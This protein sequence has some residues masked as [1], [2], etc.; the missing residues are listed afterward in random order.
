MVLHRLI[1]ISHRL[2]G[3]L[4]SLLVPFDQLQTK[5]ARK[6]GPPRL[7]RI[8]PLIENRLKK[9][10]KKLKAWIQRHGIEAYRLYDR[11]IPEYPFQVDRYNDHLLVYVKSTKGE[12]AE[13]IERKLDELKSALHQIFPKSTL[14][15]KK[16]ESQ[17][18]KEQYTRKDRQR[19]TFVV[20]EHECLFEINPTDYLDTGLFLDHRPLREWIY[21]SALGKEFLNLFC[22]TGSVSVAAALGGAKRTT[23]VDMSKTYINWAKANFLRNKLNPE[24][25]RFL[26]ENAL[27]FLKTAPINGRQYDMIFLD[28]PTFSNSKKMSEVFEVEKDQEFLV[29]HCMKILKEDGLLYFSTNKRKFKLS[30]KLTEKYDVKNVTK[31]SIPIDFRDV[32]IHHCFEIRN[33]TS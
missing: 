29:R 3:L 7:S 20:K 18:G 32:K 27:K 10:Q 31:P 11:D 22:Y 16:R 2:L 8:A 30:E 6:K 4:P 14:L 19:N 24:Q 1:S 5:G 28:P 12:S 13:E 17:K 15:V 33:R 9:N 23:S 26:E 21:K 25:H